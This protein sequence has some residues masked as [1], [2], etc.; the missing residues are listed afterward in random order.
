[1]KAHFILLLF[2]IA[3]NLFALKP[4]I[5]AQTG[6]IQGKVTNA[7]TG[8]TMPFVNVSIDVNGNLINT[9]TD[10]DGIYS[11]NSLRPEFY[12]LTFSDV[13]FQTIQIEK[14]PVE[15]DKTTFLNAQLSLG[16][17]LSDSLEIVEYK[18]SPLPSCHISTGQTVTAEEIQNMPTPRGLSNSPFFCGMPGLDAKSSMKKN[19]SK[20]FKKMN[21]KRK[22][23]KRKE[24][25]L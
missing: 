24:K 23:M 17:E 19:K 8:E 5:Q 25:N 1:M 13:A 14:I 15:T 22:R 6:E 11:L 4:F 10:F 2:A 21:R 12:T 3:F 16:S 18:V 9:T 20:Q 7:K